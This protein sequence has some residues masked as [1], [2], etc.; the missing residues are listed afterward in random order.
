MLKQKRLIR[1]IIGLTLFISFSLGQTVGK[2]RGQI[3][4]EESQSLP[5]VQIIVKGESIGTVTD[6]DGIFIIMGL[7]PGEYD[8]QFNYIGYKSIILEKV[9]VSVNRTTEVNISMAIQPLEFQTVEH[10]VFKH[11][12]KKDQ[13]GSVKNINGK[14]IE[15]LP[16]TNVNEILESQAGIVRGHFRGGRSSDVSYLIDGIPVNN[17]FS[18]DAQLLELPTEIIKDIEVITGTFNAEYGK[19]MSGIV[20]TVTDD[21]KQDFGFNIKLR[22]NSFFSK[23]SDYFIGLD[24]FHF[25]KNYNVSINTKGSIYKNFLSGLINVQIQHLDGHL[26]GV[27]RFLPADYSDFNHTDIAPENSPWITN[28]NNQVYYSE[29]NGDNSLIPMNWLK[30]NKIFAKLSFHPTQQ[31]RLNYSV[32]FENIQGQNYDHVFKYKPTGRA[33]NYQNSL[34]NN[35]RFTHL[36]NPKLTYEL[37]ISNL[38][39]IKY[40]Y[41]FENPLDERY[42]SDRYNS[43][44][45]GFITGGMDK[46]N[47]EQLLGN[48]TIK[49]NLSSQINNHHAIKMGFDYVYHIVENNPIN[50]VLVDNNDPDLFSFPYDSINNEFLF[51]DIELEYL[52]DSLD[53]SDNYKMNPYEFSAFIQDKLEFDKMVLNLGLRYDYFNPNTIYPTQLRNPGNQLFYTIYD[54]EGNPILDS[55]G[56]PIPDSTRMS[57]YPKAKF[58]DQISPRFGLSYSIE[59]YAVM[60]FS[61]GHFFQMPSFYS[62]YQNYKFQIPVQDFQTIIGNPNLKAEKTVQYELGYWQQIT[63]QFD[64]EII[65]YYRDIYDLLSTEVIA[66]YN[67]IKYGHFTNKDYGNVKGLELSLNYT[68]GNLNAT[69]N[70][71]LQYTR[72]N[73]DNPTSSFY[74]E[75]SGEDALPKLIP[76]SWDQRHTFNFILNWTKNKFSS[77]VVAQYNSGL[78]YTME[79]LAESPLSNQFIYPNNAH[80]PSS[81]VVN[82]K[83]G[84]KFK[85]VKK[86]MKFTVIINNVFDVLIEEQV[87]NSTG[88][89]TSYHISESLQNSFISNYNEI[90]DMYKNPSMFAPPREIKMGIEWQF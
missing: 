1:F 80:G 86:L 85:I 70:Y 74:R 18:G 11:S 65:I 31:F 45:G 71:T 28:I 16:A 49:W 67:N 7:N 54:I 5:G 78:P 89:A 12:R 30:S 36:I 68:N 50:L 56:H 40:A 4:N 22:S 46:I 44:G 6:A 66:T 73:A 60:H 3:L 75:S 35:F 23:K 13:T 38:M 14:F 8:L 76:M 48:T 87:Y 77:N 43:Y 64:G 79:P 17:E 26:F 27:N 84:Y 24:Q 82:S 53:F 57:S 63:P 15:Q 25:V 39:T 52:P 19:A 88:R 37:S 58:Q 83:L 2:I 47:Q 21:G 81:V 41:L 9:E 10:T 69:V 42:I 32:N 62:L 90:D 72:G 55:D 61:Y 29:A 34:L 51:G 59:D 33:T 20:N